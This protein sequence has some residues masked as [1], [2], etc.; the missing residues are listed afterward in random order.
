MKMHRRLGISV[1]SAAVA[2]VALTGCGAG[3]GSS[4]G[5]K[6]SVTWMTIL[7]TPTTPETDGVI[8]TALEEHTGF[9]IDFQWIPSASMDEKL[10]AAIASDTLADV[11]AM[12]TPDSSTLRRALASG[13]FWD[14]EEYLDDFPNL[15]EIDPQTLEAAKIDGHLYGVPRQQVKARY[16][17][18]VRQD[19]LDNL[20]LDVP[21][22]IDELAEVARAFTEDDPDGNG[23]DDT[24]GF[25]DRSE[26]F[27]YNFRTLSGYFGAGSK[28]ELN[29]N[30]EVVPSFTT[31]AFKEAMEWYRGLYEDGAVNNEFVTVQKSNQRDA[32]A[33]NKGGMVVTGLFDASNLLALGQSADPD[34]P[35]EWALVSDIT[36]DGGPRRVLSDTNG[37][38]GGWYAIP[39]SQIKTEEDL[40]AV[41]GFL[42]SLLDK[43]AFDLMTN[44][45]EG[46]HY[47]LNEDGVVTILDQP[48]WEQEVQPFASSRMSDKVVTYAST[49]PYVNE[50]HELMA[51]QEEFAVINVA[52]S[53]TSETYDSRWTELEQDARDAYNK[54]IVGQIEMSDYEAAMDKIA[55]QGLDQITEEFTASYEAAN[56]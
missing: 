44:G 1:A 50:A 2:A 22:T 8:E 36:Y 7:H 48:T 47:E 38:L 4:D 21:H 33:Q 55:G 45:I 39:K 3:G 40:R 26:S 24:T 41:L 18:L 28:F 42:D 34:T 29:D 6:T 30:G 16:G 35:M 10:N 37:G 20:G 5:P 32:I 15:A 23:K 17:V 11:V 49:T 12:P 9:D 51:E 14:V 31:D 56:G 25:Y 27:D 19:W 13:Q 43:E 52:Q 46:T 53:L 54:Y